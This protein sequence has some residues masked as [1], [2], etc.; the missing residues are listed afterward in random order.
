MSAEHVW[1]ALGDN[2]NG[3]DE[4]EIKITDTGW[5]EKQTRKTSTNLFSSRI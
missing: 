1:S 4:V 5:S 3:D 2:D